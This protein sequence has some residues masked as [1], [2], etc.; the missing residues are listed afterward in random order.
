MWLFKMYY[1]FG[2]YIPD[3][4][5]RL[6][7]LNSSEKQS[8]LCRRSNAS[9]LPGLFWGEFLQLLWFKYY[10]NSFLNC[11]RLIQTHQIWWLQYLFESRND[12]T[13]MPCGHTI[14]KS[15]LNEM[16][17]HF[18]WVSQGSSSPYFSLYTWKIILILE[19][20]S[21]LGM[22]A[23]S[24]QSQSV[25]CQRFGRNLTLRLLLHECLSNIKIKWSV[26]LSQLWLLLLLLTIP[27]NYTINSHLWYMFF[28]VLTNVSFLECWFC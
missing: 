15:C 17:E 18:Q 19:F 5:H 27:A 3:F 6:L 14:H 11:W 20:D 22:H 2:H 23:L 4:V 13:V 26:F 21:I 24:A 1:L 28:F 10:P 12:V 8:P 7:L 25:T 9:W 16:R